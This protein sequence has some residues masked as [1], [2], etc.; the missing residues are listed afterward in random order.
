MGSQI[1]KNK[2]EEGAKAKSSVGKV[3]A[4]WPGFCK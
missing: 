1:K 2:E 4:F 3:W